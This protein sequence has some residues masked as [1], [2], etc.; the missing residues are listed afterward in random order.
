MKLLPTANKTKMVKLLRAKGY[1]V[2][3]VRKACFDKLGRGNSRTYVLDWVDG[4]KKRQRAFYSG[5]TG[6]PYL[7]VGEQWTWLTMAEVIELGLVEEK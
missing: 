3:S 4:Q 7:S 6:R 5:C 1:D 2:P